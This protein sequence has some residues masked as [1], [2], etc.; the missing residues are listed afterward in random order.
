MGA[1]MFHGFVVEFGVLRSVVGTA[2][3]LAPLARVV[4][5]TVDVGNACLLGV[6]P[7]KQV[8]VRRV[9]AAMQIDAGAELIDEHPDAGRRIFQ[10]VNR[11]VGFGT[12]VAEFEEQIKV[13]TRQVERDRVESDMAGHL[14]EGRGI[15][16][17]GDDAG[18]RWR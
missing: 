10:Q 17:A 9:M 6:R 2:V 13:M 18:D 4:T 14:R 12:A 7:E 8:G 11:T 3:E 1:A 5:E 16:L 15:G